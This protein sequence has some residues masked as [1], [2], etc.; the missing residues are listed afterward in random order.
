[1]EAIKF[2]EKAQFLEEGERS[3]RYFYSLEKSRRADQTI[4]ILTKENLDTVSGP[5][6]LL[7]ETYYFY[8]TLYTAQPCDEDA[9]NQFLN[10]AIPKLPD[11]A[12]NSC[13]GLITEEEPLKAVR[14]M[15]SNK[16]P[17]VDG[18]TTHFYK[19]FWPLKQKIDTCL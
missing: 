1:M 3:T 4:R 8:K 15:E 19:H 18:L 2:R 5:Q 17:G 16:S 6:D 7:K 12:R 11:N 9:R 14:S 13:E 10:A